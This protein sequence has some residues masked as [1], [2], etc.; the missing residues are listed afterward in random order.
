MVLGNLEYLA[1]L[2]QQSQ[3][4][5]ALFKQKKGSKQKRVFLR[6]INDEVHATINARNEKYK[7]ATDQHERFKEFVEGDQVLVH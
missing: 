5:L 3:Q 7:E 6:H 1:Q 4:V 2:L